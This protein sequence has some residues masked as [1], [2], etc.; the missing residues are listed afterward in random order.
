MLNYPQLDPEILSIGPLSIRWYGLMYVFGFL[1]AWLL[2]RWRARRQKEL[3]GPFTP[4]QFDDVLIWGLFGVIIG[5][6]LGYVLFYMPVYY[7]HNPLEIFFIWQGGMS[8]HGG[9]I[10]VIL[11]QWPAGRRY[12]ASLLRTMDFVAPLAPPGLFFGRLGNFINGELW[13]RPAELPWSMAFP[14][15]GPLARHPSQ[16]YEAALEGLALFAILWLFSKKPRPTGAVSGLFLLCY[17]TFRLSVEFARE[18]DAFLGF[19]FGDF[20]TMGMLL[21]LPML[22]LGAFLL[23]RAGQR[24]PTR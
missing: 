9:L 8:F 16:L 6:R 19:V 13:G 22:A 3:R 4:E 20:L 10:G 11:F 5:A 24:A 14:G 23:F 2:G 18:P 17:G 12:K 15:A 1:A 21:C 7:L